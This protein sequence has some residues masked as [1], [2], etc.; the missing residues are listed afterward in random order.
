MVNNIIKVL[1]L[2]VIVVLAYFVV[3]SIMKPVRFNKA[4]DIRSKAVIQNLVDI[5]TSEM[6]FKIINGKYTSSFDTLI[7]FLQTGEIPVVNIIPDP[8]DT[9]FTKTIRDTIGY[10]PVIDSLF[11]DRENYNVDHI[12]YIPYTDN[13]MFDLDAGVIEKGGVNVHVFEAQALYDIILKGLNEQMVIN[14][15]AGKEQIEKYPGIKV[16]SMTEASIDG[17]WE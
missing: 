2:V 1:L 7:D 4:V 14:L 8:E 17:N 12:K 11:N 16:G 9:T 6:A 3:E 13:V 15:I 5:R 10:I